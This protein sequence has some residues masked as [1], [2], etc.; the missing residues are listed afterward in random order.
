M[1]RF[2]NVM[3]ETKG[4]IDLYLFWWTYTIEN[5]ITGQMGY[6]IFTKITRRSQLSY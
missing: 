6:Y 4:I 5:N 2:T 1:G 3:Q